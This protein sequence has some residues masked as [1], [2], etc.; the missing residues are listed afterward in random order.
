MN[1]IRGVAVGAGYFSQFHY[2]AWSRIDGAEI[3]AVCDLDRPKAEAVRERFGIARIYDDPAEAID[4]EQPDFVDLITPPATHLPLVELAA[5]RG[6]AVICQ[7]A[8]A[9]TIGEAKAIVEAAD[10]AGIR[11]M[12][13]ENFR[14]QPWHREIKRLLDLGAIGG[15]LHTLGF[16]SRPGDGWG[17]DAYLARQPYFREMPRFLVFEAGVHFIDTFRFLAGE[18]TGVFARLRRLNPAI[19]GEDAGIL[20]F[21]FEG[22][23]VGL[24][25]ANRYNESTAEDPR[26][27]FGEFLV[28]GDGGSIRLAADG[29]ITVQPLGEPERVHEYEHSRR[30]FAGDCV[31]ATQRHFV[32]RLR[33]GGPFET[34]GPEYLKTLAVQEACYESSRL[35]RP[36]EVPR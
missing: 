14:F 12:V 1:P 16:R 31:L 3:V 24:W 18:V 9:P 28:E 22:G 11:F 32:D 30:G 7:K 5:D 33:D 4:R 25:D 21:E 36:V 27:T 35:G 15:R 10:S 8:L 29:T 26:Y 23:A 2:D 20:I 34:S 6:V 13:H 17:P 19:A